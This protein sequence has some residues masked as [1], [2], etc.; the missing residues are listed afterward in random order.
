MTDRPTVVKATI[1]AL[2]AGTAWSCGGGNA[3]SFP[4][5]TAGTGQWSIP[6]NQVVDGGPGKDGIASIDNPVFGA[7]SMNTETADATLVVGVRYDGETKAYPHD[8]LDWHEIVNDGSKAAPFVLSYCPL[9]GSGL[10]WKADPLAGDPTFGVSGL[11]YE[12]NLILY[13]RE[14]DSHWSQM[15]EE[16]VEG[17]N[18]GDRA[19]GIQV[20]ETTLATWRSM[21]PNSRLMTRNTGFSRDY[22]ETPYPGY[23][24][25]SDLIFSVSNLD[26]RLH[27][28]ARVIGITTSTENKAY[29]ING[30]GPATAAI[31]D[32]V[33]G[34]PIIVV[35]NSTANIAAIFSRE[36]SDGTILDFTALDGQLPNILQD[37]E[38]NVWDV[39]GHAVSGPRAG[40]VLGKTRSY[41]AYWFAWAVF[42]DDTILHFN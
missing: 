23:T 4:D 11:L 36:L 12:S 26:N 19:Q 10:A 31:N 35:G 41:T 39:F 7:A 40:T 1:V 30:F 2:L 20:V 6:R 14:T 13:D 29:E 18:R 32:H 9:T 17:L 3:E 22:D 16:S 27:A 37:S 42:H 28:K 24:T 25:N 15:L 33:G 21:Y 34:Q 8:I 38:G 5:P